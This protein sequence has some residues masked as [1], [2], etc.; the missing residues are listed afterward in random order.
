M[1]PM[2]IRFIH[3]QYSKPALLFVAIILLVFTRPIMAEPVKVVV[4]V[5]PLQTIVE[6]V[7]GQHVTVSTMVREG[8]SPVTYA[9]TP[10]QLITLEQAAIYFRIGVAFED[11]WMARMQSV[12]PAMRIVDVRDGIR[13]L[14]H[15]NHKASGVADS[16][17]PHVWTSPERVKQI[18]TTV[19]DTLA[20]VDPTHRSSY[21]YNYEQLIIQLEQVDETIKNLLSTRLDKAFLVYHPA[22]GYFAESYGLT[23]VAIEHEGKQPGARSLARLMI[24][25]RQ[26][27]IHL[28]V[29]QP[30]YSLHISQKIADSTHLKIVI[31]DPLAADF[32]A[33]LVMLARSLSEAFQG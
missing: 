22:W 30:Q 19:R 13:L 4:S 12:N 27:G 1:Y 26:S 8:F 25:V 3:H 33:Q 6:T 9:P 23:Q 15:H 2:I 16:K 18:A 21:E 17:D 7:G 29:A 28:L 31:I 20:R 5:L 14:D 32:L 10:K 11:S 24:H